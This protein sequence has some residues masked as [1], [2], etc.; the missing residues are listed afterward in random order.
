M[1]FA[2]DLLA[3]DGLFPL[4]GGQLLRSLLLGGA[5]VGF[6]PRGFA[7]GSGSRALVALALALLRGMFPP[8]GL[9]L[10]PPGHTPGIPLRA[11]FLTGVPCGVPAPSAPYPLP[12]R[13]R[14]SP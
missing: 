2:R 3:C 8:H 7:P 1:Q 10:L 4:F 6:A 9:D 12:A 14:L 13:H 11:V 5:P